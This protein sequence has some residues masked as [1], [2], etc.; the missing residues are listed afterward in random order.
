M[1]FSLLFPPLAS[2]LPYSWRQSAALAQGILSQ[3]P[4]LNVTVEI[5]SNRAKTITLVSAQSL[6]CILKKSP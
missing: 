2:I 6:F 3:S 1:A 5:S 4:E